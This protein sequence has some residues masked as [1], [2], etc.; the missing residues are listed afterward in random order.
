ML[1]KITDKV[2]Y[3]L[4]SEKTDRSALGLICG[5]K[6]SLIVDSGNS[7]SHA[8]EFLAEISSMNIPTLKYLVITHYHWDH[9][10]GIKDINLTTISSEKTKE[11]LEEMQKYKWDDASLNKYIEE[12]LYNEFTVECIKEEIPDRENFNVGGLDIIYK[13][14][15]EID[16]GGVTCIIKVIGGTHTEDSAVI[17]VP[18]EK[19]VFLGDCIYGSKYNGEYGYT[20][21][22]LL[23]MVDE[24]QKFD[25]DYFVVSHEELFSKK[26]I[27]N[28]FNQLKIAGEIVDISTSLEGVIEQFSK[29][30][31]R[32]PSEE[33]TFYI[34]CF[35]NVNKA[36]K[37]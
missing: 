1:E 35:V 20:Q 2:F 9:V 31:N 21:E 22:K 13:D 23:P 36:I 37:K 26:D 27:D 7:P 24:I 14:C 19:V 4:R 33:E 6:Y 10:F 3:M 8:K 28:L 12:G 34:K 18:E 30:Y 15:V 29:L 16:L 17:Y 5:D 32:E 25:A 11:E